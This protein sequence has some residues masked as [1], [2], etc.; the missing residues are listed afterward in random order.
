MASLSNRVKVILGGPLSF[1]ELLLLPDRWRDAN[2]W[3]VY[4]DILRDSGDDSKYR[5]VGSA[6]SKKGAWPRL[7][8][9][10]AMMKG[11]KKLDPGDHCKMVGRSD[12]D[13]NFRLFAYFNKYV[14]TL[15]YPLLMEF[16]SSI[17][18][19]SFSLRP[20]N[21]L[22]PSVL[23]MIKR[24][25]P[26]DV[27]LASHGG[28]NRAA[29]CLQGL[30]H[31]HKPGNMICKHCK[32][33][34][35]T[36]WFSF[37]PG[38]PF[39]DLICL[40]CYSFRWYNRCERPLY[41]EEHRLRHAFLGKPPAI[42][43]RCPGCTRPVPGWVL[44]SGGPWKEEP[45]RLR[46]ECHTCSRRSTDRLV[47]RDQSVW[48]RKA[49]MKLLTKPAANATCPGCNTFFPS[50]RYW[51]PPLGDSLKELLRQRYECDN[52]AHR[53]T[54]KLGTGRHLGNRAAILKTFKKPKGPATCPG[55]KRYF[56]CT[57]EWYAPVGDI[58]NEPLRQRH[59]CRPCSRIPTNLLSLPRQEQPKLRKAGGV[60][61]PN[62]KPV[63]K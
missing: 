31:K 32:R 53:T 25:T 56:T 61:A 46:W 19:Q 38:V 54:D 12:V 28:L 13:K 2:S 5:Y 48:D 63:N 42:G 52:C 39:S 26:D 17:L 59:E 51:K 50:T 4:T 8:G 18:L 49:A 47:K 21:W 55:C 10:D 30:W 40:P 33:K 44:P 62:T 36:R 29:Q 27:P 15:P 23:D 7:G 9:Y 57:K 22:N 16:C 41:L 24:A 1:E 6:C 3:G 34:D 14:V 37:N 43:E 35:S 60:A 58:L 20:G 45:G 11:L